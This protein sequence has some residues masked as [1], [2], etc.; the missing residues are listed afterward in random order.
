MDWQEV[1]IAGYRAD[2]RSNYVHLK[3]SVLFCFIFQKQDCLIV[4]SLT[5]DLVSEAVLWI[6]GYSL[7]ADKNDK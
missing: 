3:L 7:L 2:A 5:F 1:H 4:S 6:C